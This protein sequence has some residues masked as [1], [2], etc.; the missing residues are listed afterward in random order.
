MNEPAATQPLGPTNRNARP[1]ALITGASR[2]IG[3]LTVAEFL[4]AGF[5]V[6]AVARSG[7]RLQ[8]LAAE[9]PAEGRVVPVPLD[10]TDSSALMAGVERVERELG[11]VEVLVNNAGYG[12][13]GAMEDVPREELEKLF[14]VNVFAQVEMTQ[15]VLPHMRRRGRGRIIFVSSVQGRVVI[16]FSGAYGAS[17]FALEGA[18]DALRRETRLFG[19]EVVLLEPGPV[20]TE[21]A[22]HARSLSDEILNNTAS[23]YHRA[24]ATYLEKKREINRSAVAP[25][26]VARLIAKIARVRRPRARYRI[27]RY[28]WLLPVLAVLLPTRLADWLLMRP[29]RKAYRSSGAA[30]E[31][32]TPRAEGGEGSCNE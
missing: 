17:K 26:K 1:V 19:V 23:V 16:P 9:A 31:R 6:A 4:R 20:A 29:Y 13:R 25:E 28:A 27:Q 10:I 5:D 30:D 8:A 32:A 11:A 7:E 22:T 18:A 2:G 12:L 21:F 24:Y 15:A 14:L 3:A